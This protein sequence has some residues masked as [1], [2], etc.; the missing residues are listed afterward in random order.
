MDH[1]NNQYLIEQNKHN[2]MTNPEALKVFWGGLLAIAAIA[3]LFILPSL[4]VVTK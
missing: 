3:S 4:I 2:G 1:K